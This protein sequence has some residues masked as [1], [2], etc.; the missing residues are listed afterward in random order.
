IWY[1]ALHGKLSCRLV[2]HQTVP[3]I[4]LDTVFP[5]CLDSEDHPAHFLF[6]CP[7]KLSVWQEMLRLNF[8][9]ELQ[10]SDIMAAIYEFKFPAIDSGTSVEF[11]Q[12]VSSCLLA[13]WIYYWRCVFDG[14]PF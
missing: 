9:C 7:N 4:F 6:L 11:C 13:C 12:V 10:L 3:E 8:E 2:L 5:I 14:V 1:R